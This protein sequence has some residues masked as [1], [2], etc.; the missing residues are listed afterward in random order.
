MKTKNTLR[1]LVY[2]MALI[3]ASCGSESGPSSDP[4][5]QKEKNP[6]CPIGSFI[7]KDRYNTLYSTVSGQI[8][9][10]MNGCESSGTIMCGADGEFVMNIAAKDSVAMD[11]NEC[12]GVGTFDCRYSYAAGASSNTLITCTGQSGVRNRFEVGM[13]FEKN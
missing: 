1:A 11:V 13:V 8:Y 3:L 2:A 5:T 4:T 7:S 9:L 6:S 10:D 12:Q